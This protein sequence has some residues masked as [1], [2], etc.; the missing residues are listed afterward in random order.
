MVRSEK[1][2]D[3]HRRFDYQNDCNAVTPM[4]ATR[5]CA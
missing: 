3:D 4:A 5:K 2:D 1:A